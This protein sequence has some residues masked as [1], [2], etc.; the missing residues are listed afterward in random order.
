MTK[1]RALAILIAIATLLSWPCREQFGVRGMD[2]T[3]AF[4]VRVLTDNLFTDVTYRIR[5]DSSLAPITED[6]RIIS[7]FVYRGRLLIRDEY[8]PPVPTSKWEPNKEYTFTRRIYIP[9]FIDEFDPGFRGAEKLGL[10]VGLASASDKTGDPGLVLFRKTVRVVPSADSPVLVYLSGWYAQ[11][12]DP[13]DPG[14]SWRWTS[15]EA[16]VAI[17]NP[18]RDALLVLRGRAGLADAG[19]KVTVSIDGKPLDE[20]APGTGEFERHFTVR[21][22][23]LGDKDDFELVI[24]VDKTFVPARVTPGSNDQREL[25]VRISLLYFR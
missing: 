10:T 20:F 17:D 14:R 9:A 7:R 24:G 1:L 15:K 5:T 12:T 21:K 8:E 22:E 2:L 13:Q 25:G 11:E 23:W 4:S 19:Q 16:R 6:D 3:V 18:G